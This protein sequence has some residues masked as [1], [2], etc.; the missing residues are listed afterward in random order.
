M[1]RYGL[2][3][4]VVALLLPIQLIAA[5]EATVAGAM[6]VNGKT[7]KLTHVYA[8][9]IRTD[10]PNEKIYRLIFSDAA[11][12]DKDL[13]LFPDV[14]IKAINDGTLHAMRAGLDDHGAVDSVEIYMPSETTWIKE[15]NKTEL[16]TFNEKT[17]AGRVHLDK[18]ND[19]SG[20]Y[21]YDLKFSA[22]IKQEADLTAA[23]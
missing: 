3:L 16:K 9:A 21:A 17:I 18:Y 8:I 19:G 14:L 2:L 10:S 1:C 23:Q 7:I 20:T 6:I 22:P 5:E 12:S 15:G 4:L 13:A 11:I